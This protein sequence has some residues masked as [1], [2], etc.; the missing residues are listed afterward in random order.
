MIDLDDIFDRHLS[1]ERLSGRTLYVGHVLWDL[2][3][4][5]E[6]IE[7]LREELRDTRRGCAWCTGAKICA[8]CGLEHDRGVDHN[9]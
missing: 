4:A 5:L 1:P 8:R 2:S 7:R 3:R 9:K 6:E